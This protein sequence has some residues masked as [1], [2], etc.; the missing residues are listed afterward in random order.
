M[1]PKMKRY[2]VLLL[3][4]IGP[5]AAANDYLA[6]LQ[7]QAHRLKLANDAQW[8]SLLHYARYPL[9]GQLKSQ[10][11]DPGFFNAPSG[12]TDPAAE[13]D[14]TL[15]RFFDA[16][17]IPPVKQ[18]AQCR[19]AARY[20]WLKSKLQFDPQL[21]PEQDCPR[22]K[23]WLSALN[24]ES[25]TLIFPSAHINSPASM[26][27]H[28]LLRIDAKGQSEKTRLL[29]YTI[30]YAANANPG[31]G[32]TFAFKGLTG[33]YPGVMSNSPYY[34]KV[35]EYTDM[36]SRDIWEYRLTLTPA[37]IDQLLRHAWEISATH[38]DYWFFDEN[39][40][41]LLLTLLDVGRPGLNLAQQ[42][43][44]N[45]I[46]VDT[47]RAVM[48][49]PG[50]VA[51]QLFR[52]SIGSELAFRARLLSDTERQQAIAIATGNALPASVQGKKNEAAQLEFA[53]Y[54]VNFQ[55][56][57][58]K[59]TEAVGFPRLQAIQQ[60]RS[61]LPPLDLPPPPTPPA[62]E[63][64]H[65]S[66]RLTVQ[67]G[68]LDRKAATTVAFHP[69]YHELLDPEAGFSRG[70]QIRF[71][72]LAASQKA[73]ERWQ[74]QH[75]VPVDIISLAPL[76]DW[77]QA[78]SWRVRFG[79][80]RPLSDSQRLGPLLA[81]GPG[82]AWD[83]GKMLSYLYLDNTLLH[84]KD[85]EAGWSAGTGPLAGLIW[86]AGPKTR[87]HLELGRQWY[88]LSHWQKSTAQLKV[89][90]QINA[91]NN[92]TFSAEWRKVAHTRQNGLWLGWQHY[93]DN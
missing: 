76:Q 39:C 29:A 8:L 86:D 58:G 41:Y 5:L 77:Y 91:L 87:L 88:T 6:Q 36:E 1:R 17:P 22:L 56:Q 3:F 73:G 62:P 79:A 16:T 64:G 90:H 85:L 46:P 50:L 80:E 40:S 72:E 27:G 52:P 54:L 75:F 19:F 37:E 53:D 78:P 47:V 11:D 31:D 70:A 26:F 9:A 61:A 43:G 68:I 44:V 63:S 65:P 59:I 69:A 28:T 66:P 83:K 84:N 92:L 15:A 24:P 32:L 14:A 71:F 18:A 55:G 13:L 48:A 57:S 60:Q 21:L 12:A 35:R 81:G 45:V 33:L 7:T 49:T 2:L 67:A 30:N 93:F 25:A 10:A 38:F 42:F 74:I 4:L 82:L 51:S 23:E 20:R 89:R 34:V